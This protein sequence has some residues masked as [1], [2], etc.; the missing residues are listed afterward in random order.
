[1]AYLV[2]YFVDGTH[3]KID[4]S[5]GWHLEGNGVLVYTSKGKSRAVY[6]YASIKR[7][8]VVT[9]TDD[10]AAVEKNLEELFSE[11]FRMEGSKTPVH[12]SLWAVN[13][14][15]KVEG[16]I[17]PM[18]PTGRFIEGVSSIGRA[19]NHEHAVKITE[20]HNEIMRGKDNAEGNAWHYRK[21]RNGIFIELSDEPFAEAYDPEQAKNI[22]QEHNR[23]LSLKKL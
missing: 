7:Y 16:L 23:M 10:L 1:M 21:Q 20:A 22:V 5:F 13:A 19:A 17:V 12:G 8:D 2:F 15:S 18:S 11:K 4:C 14:S 3:E 9:N 6:P